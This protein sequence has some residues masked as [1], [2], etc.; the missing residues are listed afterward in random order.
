MCTLSRFAVLFSFV[1]WLSSSHG[2]A[3]AGA[4]SWLPFAA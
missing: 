1:A 2:I 4:L 3:L